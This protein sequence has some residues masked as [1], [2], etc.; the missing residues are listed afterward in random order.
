MPIVLKDSSIPD[1]KPIPVTDNNVSDAINLLAKDFELPAIVKAL[2]ASID[3][4]LPQHYLHYKDGEAA[5]VSSTFVGP[6][7]RLNATPLLI[8]MQEAEIELTRT[9]KQIEQRRK[10]FLEM[11]ERKGIST[12]AKAIAS[13]LESDNRVVDLTD[14]IARKQITPEIIQL[15]DLNKICFPWELE[16]EV[17]LRPSETDGFVYDERGLSR[18]VR[19]DHALLTRRK[20]IGVRDDKGRIAAAVVFAAYALPEATRDKAGIDGALMITY[21][22]VDKG[23]RYKGLGKALITVAENEA[24]RFLDEKH[25]IKDP[26]IALMT[27]QNCAYLMDLAAGFH[28]WRTCGIGPLDRLL[29]WDRLGQRQVKGLDYYQASIREVG[30]E[31]LTPPQLGLYLRL[32]PREKWQRTNH[33]LIRCSFAYHLSTYQRMPD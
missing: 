11:L 23:E 8:E 9:R 5:S 10:I 12:S 17:L 29:V 32:P 1:N 2:Y 18:Y 16:A 7:P 4:S 19:A 14:T 33:C 30:S 15:D 6:L 25:G 21:L 31:R 13:Y 20:I 22:M 24:I 3:S 26:Q 28:D 27:E